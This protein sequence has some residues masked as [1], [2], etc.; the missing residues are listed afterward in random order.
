MEQRLN[1]ER[2][3]VR[4]MNGDWKYRTVESHMRSKSVW[5]EVIHK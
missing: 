5:M 2:K 4:A 1:M 3:M